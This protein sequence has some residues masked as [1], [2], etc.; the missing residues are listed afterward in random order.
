MTVKTY[1]AYG[2]GLRP[3][4]D[5]PL[6]LANRPI[7]QVGGALDLTTNLPSGLNDPD[8]RWIQVITQNIDLSGRPAG[9]VDVSS[10]DTTRGNHQSP[11][12]GFVA[13]GQPTLF[14]RRGFFDASL[15]TNF[16]NPIRWS[17]E[18][19]LVQETGGHEV[20]VY[21]EGFTWGWSTRSRTP[22]FNYAAISGSASTTSIVGIGTS[23][24]TA[25]IVY[26]NV[27]PN[28]RVYFV[29]SADNTLLGGQNGRVRLVSGPQSG[30]YTATLTDVQF[31]LPI[32][33]NAPIIHT[34]RVIFSGD[35]NVLGSSGNPNGV[36]STSATITITVRPIGQQEEETALTSSANPAVQGDMVSF[37]QTLSAAGSGYDT[38]TGSVTFFDGT[39]QIGMTGL[40]A[41]VASFSTSALAVGKHEIIAIYSGDNEYAPKT[42]FFEQTIQDT[43]GGSG[44]QL[45][46]ST[47]VSSSAAT[48]ILGQTV[49]FTATVSGPPPATGTPTGTVAF[50]DGTTSLGTATLDQYGHASIS[51]SNLA[52]GPHSITAIY[53]GDTNFI[54]SV[55]AIGQEVTR[56]PT[57]VSLQSS[58]STSVFGQSVSL[59]TSVT[60]ASG[61]AIPT[62]DVTFFDGTT[63][64]GTATVDTSGNASLDVSDLAVGSHAITVS[65]SGDAQFNGSTSSQTDITVAKGNTTAISAVLVLTATTSGSTVTEQADAVTSAFQG[66][67]LT[68]AANIRA[69]SPA[70][71]I[72][73][74][75]VT[76]YDGT[77]AIG[78]ATING[79]GNAFLDI[80]NF[81]VGTHAIT[82]SY[83]GDT[84]FN[85]SS[86]PV[87][88]LTILSVNHAPTGTDATV[89]M[90]ENATFTFSAS[91]FGFSDMNDMLL[92]NFLGVYIDTLPSTGVLLLNG[93]AVTAGQFIAVA[94]LPNLTYTAP[95]YTFGM[96]MPSFNFRV[97]DDGGTAN[98]GIDTDPIA[99]TI[100]FIIF[101]MP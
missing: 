37:T 78:D 19:F 74:G 23:D 9:N 33:A 63:A 96:T 24:L 57:S 26:P 97:K 1:A 92:H 14:D 75:T 73:N 4:F 70:D 55:A 100:T 22:S 18:T 40:S 61:S 25:T 54:S 64:L 20:T 68:L 5:R 66:Q 77:M 60:A 98:G 48:S 16:T 76:F 51:V 36:T 34:I 21:P 43:N 7:A 79:N 17:A 69:V 32:G 86:S 52:T 67:S 88:N 15:R 85:G 82:F 46:S 81:A 87:V 53:S 93:N 31:S 42:D 91:N 35:P 65:Y 3:W 62:G 94:D 41:G 8:Y 80:S 29:D 2:D 10:V 56:Q 28:A 44:S 12:M 50:Y 101:D 39:T 71:G 83:V 59:S 84:N 89:M 27:S 13:G 90:N 11:Y 30:T 99:N 6:G 38:P 58:A 45:E 72:A 47:T 49:T 95:A